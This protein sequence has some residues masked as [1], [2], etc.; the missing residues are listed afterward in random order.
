MRGCT[1]ACR[2]PW[3]PEEGIG[4][5]RVVVK[6]VYE[7]PNMVPGNKIEI[8]FSGRAPSILKH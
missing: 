5:P 2:C 8:R 6:K 1:N 4:S 7:P 3:S